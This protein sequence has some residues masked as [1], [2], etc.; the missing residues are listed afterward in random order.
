MRSFFFQLPIA[1]PHLYA[2]GALTVIIIAVRRL[3]AAVELVILVNPAA[4]RSRGS[5][6][7]FE[8]GELHLR[9]HEEMHPLPLDLHR[10]FHPLS[11]H[12]HRLLYHP[13]LHP[14]I[15]L[16]KPQNCLRELHLPPRRPC[17]PL[18]ILCRREAVGGGRWGGRPRGILPIE[19]Q[20]CPLLLAD[21]SCRRRGFERW[22]E[23]KIE[24][25]E[26]GPGRRTGLRFLDLVPL[27][28]SIYAIFALRIGFMG[29]GVIIA[30]ADD[31]GNLLPLL[32]LEVFAAEV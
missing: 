17:S 23:E 1:D 19:Q 15:H 18:P 26:E 12:L 2:P 14:L 3:P 20:I 11:L 7:A 27:L 22:A 4:S 28:Q 30:A 21:G 31:I 9:L 10:E 8:L 29:F 6:E 5:P 32:L 13:A 16:P 25:V 24:T